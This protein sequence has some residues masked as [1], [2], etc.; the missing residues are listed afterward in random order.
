MFRC[1]T[2]SGRFCALAL[3]VPQKPRQWNLPRTV[4]TTDHCFSTARISSPFASKA[5][6]SN[7]RHGN[8]VGRAQV[9]SY[10]Y[11]FLHDLIIEGNIITDMGRLGTRR[12]DA[13]IFVARILYNSKNR[14]EMIIETVP[15]GQLSKAYPNSAREDAYALRPAVLVRTRQGHIIP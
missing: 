8:R 9:R 11:W 12:I 13:N 4:L 10:G 2:S 1:T 3:V 14:F 5:L 6:C 15:C 7:I